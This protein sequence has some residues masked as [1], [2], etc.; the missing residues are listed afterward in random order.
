MVAWFYLVRV[1]KTKGVNV[2]ND[3]ILQ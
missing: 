3:H 1:D 2:D